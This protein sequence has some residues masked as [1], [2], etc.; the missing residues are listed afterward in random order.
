M[1][2]ISELHR[3]LELPKPE[4]PLVSVINFNEIKCYS[5]QS[6]SSVLYN[7]YS[8]CIKKDFKGKMKYGQNYYDFDEGVVTFFF[9]PARSCPPRSRTT[10]LFQAGGW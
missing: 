3:I 6:L 9:H 4:H 8:I 2:S 7:F 10:W 1:H 5:D